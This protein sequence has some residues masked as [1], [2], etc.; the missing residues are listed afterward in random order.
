LVGAP[1]DDIEARR[2][3]WAR[4]VAAE[5]QIV[6][7]LK[8]STT[9]V[10]E[11]DGLVLVNP[12]ATA[13]LATAGSGDVL[14]GLLGS[15]LAAGLPEFEAAAVAAY[16]HAAAG[17]LASDSGPMTALSIAAALPQATRLLLG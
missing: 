1:R 7:L 8:G 16:L 15:L 3:H 9:V 4:Y 17:Q 14:A 11:P 10:A 13:W 6:V 12:I 2:L 5:H